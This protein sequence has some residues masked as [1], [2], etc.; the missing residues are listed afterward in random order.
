M[1]VKRLPWM[2]RVWLLLAVALGV[3]RAED[4]AKLVNPTDSYVADFANV[5]DDAS[6]AQIQ[7]IC[8]QVHDKAGATIKVVTV[9]S[10][11]GADLSDFS[12]RLAENWKVGAKGTDKGLIVLLAMKE[13]QDRIEVGYGLEGVLNDAKVGDIRRSMHPQLAAGEYGPA[14]LGGVQQLAADIAA[15]AGVTL[16]QTPAVQLQPVRHRG[17]SSGLGSVIR[18]LFFI[19]VL[20][21]IFGSRRGGGGGGSGLG[22]FLLGNVLGS[23]GGGGRGDWGGGGFGGGDSGGGGGGDSGGG[24]GG[25]G[26][27]GSW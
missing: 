18:I 7:Q 15:D 27:G 26:A 21:M 1:D 10:L 13:R 17:Q 19:F 24:F 5:L 3:A 20:I 4:P 11:D 14:L 23:G 16:Q 8:S 2:F 6:K 12:I 22:W 25:G 9:N